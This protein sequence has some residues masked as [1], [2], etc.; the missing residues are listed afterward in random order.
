MP[1]G[2]ALLGY[3][4]LISLNGYKKNYKIIYKHFKDKSGRR[5]KP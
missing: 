2:R 3:T 1:A 4:D 5:S